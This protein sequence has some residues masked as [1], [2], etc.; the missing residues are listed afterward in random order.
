MLDRQTL[1]AYRTRTHKYL[2]ESLLPFWLQRGPDAAGGYLTYFDRHGRPTGE[3]DKPFLMQ[4]RALMWLSAAHRAGYGDGRCA[5][6]AAQV[7]AF[8][9]EHYWDAA[10]DG[11]VW[12]A[13][14]QGKTLHADKVGYG[15]CFGLYA[16]SEFALAVRSAQERNSGGAGW[17]PTPPS[18]AQKRWHAVGCNWAERSYASIAEHMIDTQFGGYWELFKADW[19]PAPPGRGGGDR[20]SLDVHMHML[21]AL[22]AYCELCAAAPA[23]QADA[24]GSEARRYNADAPGSEARRYNADAPGSE[25]RRYNDV[26]ARRR[27]Q[28]VID[29]IETR[30]LHPQ[31]RLG[32]IQFAADFRPLPAILFDTPWGRDAKPADGV[33]RPLDFTSYGHNL[34][35]VW[36]LLHAA[37]VLGT[38]RSRYAATVRAIADHAVR[39]GIDREA[40]GVRTEGPMTGPST[41]HEKQFWQQAEALVGFLDAYAL[42]GDEAY[43]E[44]FTNVYEF[45]FA[46][47]VPADGGG[48]WMERVARDGTPIDSALGH[49]WKAGYHTVRAMVETIRRLEELERACEE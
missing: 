1:A 49:A 6:Q 15:Q 32:Y 13:D 29:L 12:I 20:K 2:T 42:L 33:A 45:V 4:A 25:A 17:K 40:G 10:H 44:A 35:Y 7:A 24:P 22:T 16:F 43:W 47:L 31:Q 3:T 26:S 39:F 37:D 38:P 28:E 9:S 11:W 48:E 18:S 36:L 21:E 8:I 14:R 34:E 23:D 30:M 19:Q 41:L 46:K 5:E 27:L